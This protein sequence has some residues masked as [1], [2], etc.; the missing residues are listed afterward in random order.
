[1]KRD[2]KKCRTVTHASQLWL[3]LKVDFGIGIGLFL[4]S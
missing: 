4:L 2:T 3:A 1:M